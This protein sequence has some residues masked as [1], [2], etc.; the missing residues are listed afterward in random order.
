MNSA[1][2][3]TSTIFNA[4]SFGVFCRRAPSIIAIIRSRNE[5]PCSAVTR[6]TIR[7][8]MTFVPPVTALRSPPLSRMTGADSPVMAD[9]STVAMP[10]TISPSAG[11]VSPASHTNRSPIFSSAACVE[12]SWPLTN[13]RAIV[14]VRILRN[15]SAWALP[16]PSAIASAKFANRH[17]NHSH[18]QIW[19]LNRL[20]PPEV[21]RMAVVQIDPTQT[22]NMTRFLI[23]SRGF[24]F[25]NES[26][27]AWLTSSEY[28]ISTFVLI[29]FSLE[30][31]TGQH[32]SVL[33]NRPQTQHREERQR[34]DD[35]DDARQREAEG[36][37]VRRQRAR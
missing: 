31:A 11:I 30:N 5:F 12:N 2:R 37:P 14:L 15:A 8:L 9:S 27:T 32:Q 18:R 17:V 34:R 26:M 19:T 35:D 20:H 36:P 1:V 24:N 25:L 13:L 4:I 22:T 28:L 16:R 10:S 23:S 21:N 7:S 6:T 33:H 29:D 3:L